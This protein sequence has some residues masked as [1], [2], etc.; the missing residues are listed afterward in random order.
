[1]YSKI[2]EYDMVYERYCIID[3][4]P[5]FLGNGILKKN[6]FSDSTL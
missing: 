3:T 5:F 4:E 2:Y 1:M 6:K